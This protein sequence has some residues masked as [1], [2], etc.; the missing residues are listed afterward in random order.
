MLLPDSNLPSS[1]LPWAREVEKQ[2]DGLSRAVNTNEVNNAAR[3]ATTETNISNLSA[4]MAD[5]VELR[6]YSSEIP[7]SKTFESTGT[8]FQFLDT[9]GL[10]QTIDLNKQRTALIEYSAF[11]NVRNTFI[12]ANE[13]YSWYIL[14]EIFVD[15]VRVA[16]ATIQKERNFT[17]GNNPYSQEADAGQIMANKLVRLSPGPHTISVTLDTGTVSSTATTKIVV[18]DDDLSTSIIE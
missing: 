7:G 16:Y 13:S 11:Y 17:S 14:A 12:T 8:G 1:S 9:S 15:G 4:L 10:T 3:D 6:A 2:L 5:Q 18:S